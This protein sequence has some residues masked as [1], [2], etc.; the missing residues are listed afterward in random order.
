MLNEILTSIT[1]FF[2]D[3]SSG[4]RQRINEKPPVKPAPGSLVYCEMAPGLADHSGIYVGEG[5]IA[6]L[7]GRGEIELVRPIIF[8]EGS[9]RDEIYVSCR[10]GRPVECLD[11]SRR[12]LERIGQQVDYNV[13]TN[14]CHIFCYGCITGSYSNYCALLEM[15]KE[16]ARIS[17]DAN[18]WRRWDLDFLMN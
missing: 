6:H 3:A 2:E 18:E 16:Q 1:S 7:N 15:L 4:E 12:A 17:L 14:N 9:L 8:V 5:E 11:T 13:I 10:D